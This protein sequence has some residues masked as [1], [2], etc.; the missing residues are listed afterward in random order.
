MAQDW[1]YTFAAA[2]GP[3]GRL[4]ILGRSYFDRVVSSL[5]DGQECVI[6]L[7]PKKDKKTNAQTRLIWGGV[8]ED[9]LQGVLS[10]VGYEENSDKEHRRIAKDALHE[11]FCLEFGGSV[12]ERVTG[13]QVRK[14]RLSRATKDEATKYIEWA[15]RHAA[16]EY[17]VA[18]ALPGEAA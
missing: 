10:E 6:T 8:Y 2:K 14:F 5:P 13:K 18:I 11:A 4:N 1:T 12:T 7:A 9:I 16:Q 15:A 3:D 17:G